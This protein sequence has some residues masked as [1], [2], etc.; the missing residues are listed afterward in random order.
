MAAHPH[1][2]LQLCQCLISWPGLCPKTDSVMQTKQK[3]QNQFAAERLLK[4]VMAFKESELEESYMIRS[5]TPANAGSPQLQPSDRRLSS[6][7]LKDQ[8]WKIY[9]LLRKTL[10]LPHDSYR[11][12]VLP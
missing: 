2:Q 7:Y 9:R 12:E 3:H 10:P 8:P 6:L 1:P 5:I 11:Q 4:L